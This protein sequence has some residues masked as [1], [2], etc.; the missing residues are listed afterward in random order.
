MLLAPDGAD[1]P[2]ALRQAALLHLR[3]RPP[4]P[5][6]PGRPQC[7]CSPDGVSR[8]GLR[9]RALVQTAPHAV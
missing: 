6:R 3:R 9:E 5:R 7:A 2:R 4:E 1:D 8:L